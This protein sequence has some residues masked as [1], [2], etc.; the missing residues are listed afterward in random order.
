MSLFGMQ[1]WRIMVTPR[2]HLFQVSD[3]YISDIKLTDVFAI[4]DSQI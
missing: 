2:P 4:L 3:L 1:S